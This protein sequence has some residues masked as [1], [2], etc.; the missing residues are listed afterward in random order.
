MEDEVGRLFDEPAVGRDRGERRLERLL[1]DLLRARARSPASASDATYEPS[2]RSRT[3]STTVRQSAGAKHD[4]E[5]VWH[6]GPA[7]R[8][9]MS[10]ASPSQSSRISSTA[11]T[12][13]D[14]SPLR[15]S[16]SRDRLQNHAS[17]VSRV[18]RSA[19]SSIQ[20]EHEHAPVGRVLHDRGPKLR[21]R[22]GDSPPGRA[23]RRAA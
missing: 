9:R 23:A 20:R 22:H 7:G 4:V 2:G 11:S 3:R 17:P 18:R 8:T 15:Q 10:S 19:S 5:P 21:L 14:V 12:F 6:A 13:P 16:F 1:A